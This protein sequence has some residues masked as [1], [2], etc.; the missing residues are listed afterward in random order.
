MSFEVL[1]AGIFTSLQDKGRFSFTHLGVTNSGFMDE[2][3]AQA[4]NKLLD[5]SLDTNLLEIAFPNVEL[6]ASKNS[7]VSITG[8]Y[9]DFYIN[10]K[11]KK[12]WQAHN[13]KDG[14]ILKIGKIH[15][16][17]RVY[18]AVK[19]G[20]SIPKEF[21]SNSTT[22]KESLGGLNGKQI[23]DGDVL[24]F[25][26]SFKEIEKRW[27]RDNLP[28]YK[29]ELTLRVVLSYQEESFSKEEK[30]KFFS[31]EYEVTPD[32]N[33]M[34]CKLKGTPIKSS[35]DGIISEAIS[36]GSIQIPKDG[37]PIILLKERQT[38]GGYPKVG[39]VLNIDCFKLAQMKIGSKI[40][41]E[42]ISIAEAQKK[43]REFYSTFS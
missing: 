40:R 37:Q 22:I 17:Q 1:K 10:N 30:E 35:L 34:A 20:F 4:A 36:F 25:R 19:D 28:V 11:V 27:H 7:T 13:I 21:G 15:Q 16:G 9:C 38:I 32:F 43:L 5:N 42:E 3:A 24:P 26:A 12:T 2:Y 18:L 39:S 33:R 6:K 14:D 41:F 8:A 23:K 31:S 29:K